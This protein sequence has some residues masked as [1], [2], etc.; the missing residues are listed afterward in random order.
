MPELFHLMRVG[1]QQVVGSAGEQAKLAREKEDD[2]HDIV[3]R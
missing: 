2:E 1:L 3:C